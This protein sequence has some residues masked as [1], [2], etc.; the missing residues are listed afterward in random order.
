MRHAVSVRQL[1]VCQPVT[2]RDSVGC[3]VLRALSLFK[4]EPHYADLPLEPKT[5][6][7]RITDE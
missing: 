6:N 4:I 7:P 3:A 5:S 2:G 1:R